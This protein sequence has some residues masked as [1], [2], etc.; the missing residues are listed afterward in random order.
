MP[1]NDQ[2]QKMLQKLNWV[3]KVTPE[4]S[5]EAEA[6]QQEEVTPIRKKQME[7]RRHSVSMASWG[8]A[9][10][11]ASQYAC[12]GGLEEAEWETESEAGNWTN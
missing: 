6:T 3:T 1:T 9:F 4:S 12:R 2:A 11:T 7:S 8:G 10:C 5:A